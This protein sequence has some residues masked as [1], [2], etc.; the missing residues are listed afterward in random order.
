[1]SRRSC[2]NACR[3]DCASLLGSAHVLSP[4]EKE[5][6]VDG[7]IHTDSTACAALLLHI[8]ERLRCERNS[9]LHS[10]FRHEKCEK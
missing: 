6:V 2:I 10:I 4:A 1:M 7:G 5:D 3:G 9:K 8:C